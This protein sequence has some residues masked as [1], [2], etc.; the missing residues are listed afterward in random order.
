MTAHRHVANQST[1]AKPTLS[2]Q[3][4]MCPKCGCLVLV[5]MSML[6]GFNACTI[7]LDTAQPYYC[8][9]IIVPT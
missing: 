9:P 3:E 7:S 5:L 4:R 2:G 6:D 1:Q 8:I